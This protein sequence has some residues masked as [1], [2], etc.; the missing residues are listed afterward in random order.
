MPPL[1]G[2]V[3]EWLLFQAVIAAPAL[4]QA[5]LQF[6]SPA[7]GAML[8][9][10]AALA[11]A[12]FVRV[13]GIARFSAAPRSAEAEAQAHDVPLAQQI[14]MGGFA[15]LCILGGLSAAACSPRWR[16]PA[17]ISWAARLPRRA[18]VATVFALV[19]FDPARSIYDAAGHRA[20]L[21]SPSLRATLVV[22]RLSARARAAAR[23]VGL[24]LPRSRRPDTQYTASSF[25][26]PLR[27][28]YGAL[29]LLA[30]ETVVDA[31]TRRQPA[32]A[33]FGGAGRPDLGARLRGA[34]PGGFAA[35]RLN[36]CSS[37]PS[38]ATWASMFAAL[39]ILLPIAVTT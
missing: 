11:A 25:A 18:A 30:H 4:P 7:I 19:A 6:A 21:F 26:Q 24:R 1:N 38:G 12:C 22:H 17:E 33:V 20:L 8:A 36:R 39:V 29:P 27:R 10:A 16:R 31:A 32:G 23:A 28:V 15:V 9:L 2:F 3:S 37:S 13:Y 34:R 35:E 5:A 14:A